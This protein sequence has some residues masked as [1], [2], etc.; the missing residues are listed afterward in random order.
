MHE[1]Y[2][3]MDFGNLFGGNPLD[4]IK[5]LG[6]GQL[7]DMLHNGSTQVDDTTRASLGQHLLDAFTNHVP[8]T[9][10]GADAAAQ[11]GTSEAAVQSGDPGAVGALINY[12]KAHPEIIQTATTAFL[13][14]N[15]AVLAQIGPS[16]LGS[17]FGG[18]PA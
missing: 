7:G 15:P 10:T 4:L 2:Y 16:V 1:E 8:F 13:E 6:G 14:R 9:G 5:Q 11:A 12:A 18:R 17:L 3:A